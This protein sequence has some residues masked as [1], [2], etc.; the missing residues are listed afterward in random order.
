MKTLR[1]FTLIAALAL[2]VAAGCSTTSS[3]IA[4]NPA[5]FA[6]WPVAVQDKVRA[7]QVDLGF[8]QEQVRVALGEPDRIFSRTTN[9]GTTDVWVYRQEKSR[10]S[11][12]FGLGSVRGST[13]V[14]A[15]VMVGDRDWRDG[16]STRV[17]FDRAGR[18]STIETAQRGGG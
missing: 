4:K 1:P 13:G 12:G 5:A 11:F 6:E 2:V 3:R 9:D 16:E 17:V 8:T 7:G 15:G 10:F 18:V 14:G